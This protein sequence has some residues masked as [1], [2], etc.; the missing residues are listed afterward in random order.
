MN[1]IFTV[2]CVLA[3]VAFPLLGQAQV[4]L[5]V[6]PNILTVHVAEPVVFKVS[7][8]NVGA[9]DVS[10]LFI[11]DGQYDGF[12]I[13]V[14]RIG[15]TEPRRF[16]NA[17]MWEATKDDM[18]FQPVIINLGEEIS[19]VYCILYNI[20]SNEFVFKTSGEYEVCFRLRWDQKGQNSISTTARVTVIGWDKSNETHQLEAL[21]IWMNR[22][23][24]MAI[25]DG[26]SLS[27]SSQKRV[28][29]LQDDYAGTIYSELA[30]GLL[31][32]EQKQ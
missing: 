3:A 10:G 18:M 5:S 15:D 1:S 30:S 13:E 14:N 25:Q 28:Q 8:R 24:A 12:S 29:R 22:G 21:K 9:E 20:R 2:A 17:K 16:V 11:L 23:L 7:A 32:K 26:T 31:D 6:V 4:E 27:D 19:E